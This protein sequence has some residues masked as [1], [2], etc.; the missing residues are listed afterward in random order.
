MNSSLMIKGKCEERENGQ[1]DF[2]P[3][4][5]TAAADENEEVRD[6]ALLFCIYVSS[7]KSSPQPVDD[8]AGD[9]GRLL[10]H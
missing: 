4:I 5:L 2:R 8:E 3:H 7:L 1:E 10:F 9:L 6:K